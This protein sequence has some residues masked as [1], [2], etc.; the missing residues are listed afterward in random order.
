ME[1]IRKKFIEAAVRPLSD[2][3]EQQSAARA[4]LE[5]TVPDSVSG[6]E[7]AT[8]RW[9]AVDVEK[10]RFGWKKL[11]YISLAIVSLLVV[12][13][14]VRLSLNLRKLTSTIGRTNYID[15][16]HW[17]AGITEEEVARN[18]S[19]DETR[20]LFGDIT[21]N[22]YSERMK[23]LWDG[24][25]ESP[26]Y[27]SA[28]VAAYHD[29]FDTLP[30]GF[31]ATARRLDP[32]NAWFTYLAAGERARDAV[33]ARKRSE[34]EKAANMPREWD[35]L[36][37]VALDE[38]LALLR[39]SRSQSKCYNY[40]GRL[41][42]MRIGLLPKETPAE[43]VFTENYFARNDGGLFYHL[44]YLSSAIKAKSWSCGQTGDT[45][46]FR[47]LWLDTEDLFQKLDGAEADSMMR[48]MVHMNVTLGIV[49]EAVP[50]ARKLG[51]DDLVERLSP[52]F[53]MAGERTAPEALRRRGVNTDVMWI[54]GGQ[55][56]FMFNLGNTN[57]L[58]DPPRLTMEE[59]EPGRLMD[60]ETVSWTGSH[61]AW[62]ILVIGMG[63][64]A[65]FRFRHPV[66]VRRLAS[67]LEM[68]VPPRDWVWISGT[69]VV[70]PILYFLIVTRLT[71]LGGHGFSMLEN[72]L[73]TFYFDDPPLGYV[74]WMALGLL[75]FFS[76]AGALVVCLKKRCGALGLVGRKCAFLILPIFCATAYI[77]ASGW[78]VWDYSPF[79][80][81][82]AL[83]LGG[84]VPLFLVIMVFQACFSN[85]KAQIF[86][87]T[88]ARLMMVSCAVA[89]L[90]VISMAPVFKAMAYHWSGKDTLVRMDKD[91]PTGTEFE[92]RVALQFRKETREMMGD[93]LK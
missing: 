63:L 47:E 21:K 11:L 50:A 31:L 88:F 76:S 72:N 64:C 87:A 58:K 57:R 15:F 61:F 86:H 36:D 2:N 9:A 26:M 60:H 46:S 1:A 66:L 32:D 84:I 85:Y 68:L 43:I 30:P 12:G 34:A 48:E 71:P 65:A 16:F 23:A 41:N 6:C 91:F 14:F 7:E 73:T 33:Q 79:I 77:P 80:A 38:S 37:E 20:L 18:L 8:A 29:E 5:I 53:E 82:T 28:Y 78:A 69:G 70:L 10:R 89:A 90:A 35:M 4:L 44:G 42:R 52:T 25:P 92:H 24:E 40:F 39:E 3:A 74:Q 49:L 17:G 45:D 22:S 83:V 54:H 27:F 51:L 13:D 93:L 62:A 75:V 59:L 81:M 56:A 19:P 55:L 67:R